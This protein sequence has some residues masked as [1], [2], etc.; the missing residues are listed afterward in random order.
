[1]LKQSV[2]PAKRKKSPTSDPSIDAGPLA[3]GGED[4]EHDDEAVPLRTDELQ[5]IGEGMPHAYADP[6]YEA[7][8]YDAPGPHEAPDVYEAPDPEL[9]LEATEAGDLYDESPK[10]S[11]FY[12]Q[13]EPEP[14]LV[15]PITRRK[16][17]RPP[18]TLPP[19]PPSSMFAPAAH[20]EPD[21]FGRKSWRMHPA[22]APPP[23]FSE[24]PPVAMSEHPSA[25][26]PSSRTLVVRG[27]PTAWWAL[28]LV[29]VGMCVG[30]IVTVASDRKV[31]PMLEASASTPQPLVQPPAAQTL[32]AAPVGN[33]ADVP[34]GGMV[35]QAMML[36]Q[37]AEAPRIPEV[38]QAAMLASP[39]GVPLA[40]PV[41]V[42]QAALV[43]Q[44]VAA[45]PAPEPVPTPP[46]LAKP[47]VKS[48]GSRPMPP[49]TARAPRPT[50]A[51]PPPASSS[52]PPPS[53]RKP[54]PSG[55]VDDDIARARKEVGNSL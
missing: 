53:V 6:Y 48:Q 24:A 46:V 2:L 25:L 42:P 31:D 49:P 8:Q 12:R 50:A 55:P 4:S 47:A 23:M 11:V 30:F 16:I 10:P 14:T 36:P 38:P 39:G 40:V 52:P 13:R 18:N 44:A 43:P 19:P 17:P 29:M 51:P 32:P 26:L 35:P 5:V 1:L 22:G 20:P 41:A 21:A 45:S 9:V 37:H 54:V 3:F 33:V 27:R 34:Q 15:H 28:A 7:R